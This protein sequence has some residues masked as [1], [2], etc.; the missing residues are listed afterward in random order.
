MKRSP[1][2]LAAVE[3]RKVATFAKYLKLLSQYQW[4]MRAGYNK[5]TACKWMGISH[6]TLMKALKAAAGQVKTHKG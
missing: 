2:Q 3:R 4:L 6:A 5:K 1:A